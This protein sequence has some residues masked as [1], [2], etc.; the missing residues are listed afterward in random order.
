MTMDVEG[1]QQEHHLPVHETPATQGAP[2]RCG[3]IRILHVVLGSV[4]VLGMALS[5]GFGL[6]LSGSAANKETR[7]IKSTNGTTSGGNSGVAGSSDRFGTNLASPATFMPV[8]SPAVLPPSTVR[9]TMPSLVITPYPTEFSTNQDTMF[10]GGMEDRSPTPLPTRLPTPHPTPGGTIDFSVSRLEAISFQ[11]INESYESCE[12]LKDDLKAAARLWGNSY[13]QNNLYY[14]DYYDGQDDYYNDDNVV[15]TERSIDTDSGSASVKPETEE[16]ISGPNPWS[17]NNQHEGVEEVDFVQSDGVLIYT[18]Y[19]SEIVAIDAATLTVTNRTVI[20]TSEEYGCYVTRGNS[21][22]LLNESLV[23]ITTET[24][25]EETTSSTVS[26]P[27]YATRPY[28]RVWILDS[29]T[30]LLQTNTTLTGEYVSARAVGTNVYVVTSTSIDLS[31]LTRYL[32]ISYIQSLDS[33]T[34]NETVYVEKAQQQLERNVDSFVEQITGLLDCPSLQKL[35]VLQNANDT[36]SSMSSYSPAVVFISSFDASLTPLLPNTTSMLLPNKYWDVYSSRDRLVV[37]CGGSWYNS[38]T[39][40]SP[41]ETFLIAYKLSGPSVI[42]LALGSVPGTLLDQYSMDH[43]EQDGRNYIRVATTYRGVEMT[44][45]VSVLE[46]LDDS[47]G[48]MPTVGQLTGLGKPGDL[49][50]AVRFLGDRAFIVTFNY[51]DPFYTIDLTDP[52]NPTKVGELEVPGFSTYLH[53]VGDNLILG[54]GKSTDV[55]SSPV[56]FL[57]SLFDVSD[58][59]QP[60]L[61]QQWEEIGNETVSV[62]SATSAIEYDTKA[63]RYLQ[64]ESILIVPMVANIYEKVPCKPYSPL[65][66]SP[67][68]TPYP[69]DGTAAVSDIAA[70]TMSPT[71]GCWSEGNKTS[72]SLDGFRLFKID[73]TSGITEYFS[74]SHAMSTYYYS[75][76]TV[77]PRS[78][79]IDGNVVTLKGQTVQSYNLNTTAQAAPPLDLQPNGTTTSYDNDYV[80]DTYWH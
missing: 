45:L 25:S 68:P 47:A 32:D 1:G 9:P 51:T 26:T 2:M 29:R 15:T 72:D 55:W 11:S 76:T 46:L 31:I 27:I 49:I 21:L 40:T 58:L 65:T 63:F 20:P 60:R 43:I 50:F 13:I 6:N 38:S 70:P 16:R 30:L 34:M 23:V 71:V 79:V 4:V 14:F 10:A 36:L 69:L 59:S 56:S 3:G 37:A 74:V 39:Y 75:Y 66:F 53:P 54:V 80:D 67:A 73:A 5:I 19:G 41:P 42:A 35:S 33:N 8:P 24:C 22:L 17:T 61:I 44:S 7:P 78:F 64:D 28:T 12:A 48:V 52:T 18:V 57:L 77:E 62:S